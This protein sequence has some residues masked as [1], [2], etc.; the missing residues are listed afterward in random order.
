MTKP[1]LT[2]L[3]GVL[4][5]EV[6]TDS[7]EYSLVPPASLG[8]DEASVLSDH[9]SADLLRIIPE[10]K[11]SGLIIPAGLYN[12]FEILRP[13]FPLFTYLQEIYIKSQPEDD[14]NPTVLAL[15]SDPD[16]FPIEEISPS[17]EEGYGA[18]LLIPFAIIG[19]KNQIDELDKEFDMRIFAKSSASAETERFIKDHFNLPIRGCSYASLANLCAI[20]KAQLESINC[21]PLWSLIENCFFCPEEAVVVRS[22]AGNTFCAVNGAVYTQFLTYRQWHYQQSLLGKEVD[23][24]GYIQWTAMHR[25]Y[26]IGLVSHEITLNQIVDD[27]FLILLDDEE[28]ESKLTQ[29]Q[30]AETGFLYE[31]QSGKVDIVENIIEYPRISGIT[32]VINEVVGTICYQIKCVRGDVSSIDSY[33]PISYLAVAELAEA[34]TGIAEENNIEITRRTDLN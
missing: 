16:G 11:E 34:I 7:E 9:L 27:N 13:D 5:I 28:L 25:Q 32:E 4:I 29:M 12:Q 26:L 21:A 14:F 31:D 3:S 30:M 6:D 1:V 20:F 18:L 19:H 2:G 33:Y 17:R 8:R 15:G 10:L 24:S 23:E 22:E